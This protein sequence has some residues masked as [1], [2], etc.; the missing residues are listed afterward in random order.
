MLFELHN[1][2]DASVAG[3]KNLKCADKGCSERTNVLQQDGLRDFEKEIS[4]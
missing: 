3:R 1:S 4:I 2:Y